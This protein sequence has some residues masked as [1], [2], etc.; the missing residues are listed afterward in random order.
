MKS[1]LAIT[2]GFVYRWYDRAKNM[3]YIGSHWGPQDDGYVCSSRW[4]KD[5][6]KRRPDDFV[7][8]ILAVVSTSRKDLLRRE[9]TWLD[10]ISDRQLGKGVYN[11]DRRVRD[12]WHADDGKRKTAIEKISASQR[13]RP[14]TLEH[15]AAI[16][17]GNR[18]KTKTAEQRANMRGPKS[19][20]HCTAI[21]NASRG[22]R[23]Y[24]TKT[25]CPHC[26]TKAAPGPYAH[27]HGA[28]C[29]HRAELA[30]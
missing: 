27:Y 15:R 17:N 18:G 26:G 16:A 23:I 29:R 9:Q 3:Y 5:A 13:G 6:Y 22:R 2:S 20:E 25:E 19:P 1:K 7:R 8:E 11:L 28:K 4:M 12:Y 10:R 14:L 24:L 21:G 30:A